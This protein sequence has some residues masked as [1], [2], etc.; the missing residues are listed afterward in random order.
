MRNRNGLYLIIGVLVAVVAIGGVLF[1]QERHKSGI[2]VEIG[3][4]GVSVETH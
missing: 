4:G 2:D 3:D 1:Y